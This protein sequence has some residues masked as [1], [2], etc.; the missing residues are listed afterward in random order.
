MLKVSY[1]CHDT[2]QYTLDNEKKNRTTFKNNLMICTLWKLK[3]HQILQSNVQNVVT[4][5]L[6]FF[7]KSLVYI[8]Y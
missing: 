2:Q 7:S 5:Q 8:L 3:N 1:I 4:I 6:T